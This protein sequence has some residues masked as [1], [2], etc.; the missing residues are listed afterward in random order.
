MIGYCRKHPFLT[1][2][3]VAIV[4]RAL[5]VIMSKGFMAS[6]D[7]YETVNVAYVWLVYGL[8]SD[9]GLLTWGGLVEREISR[10]PLYTLS[11]YGVMKTY[12]AFGVESLDKMMYGIRAVHALLSLVTVGCAYKITERVTRSKDWALIAGLVAAAHAA[13]PFLSVRNLI[14]MVSGHFWLLSIFLIYRYQSG[15][16]DRTLFLAG[17]A[18]GLAWMIRFEL[19]FAVLP[20]PFLLWYERKRLR[21]AFVYSSAVLSMLLLSGVVDLYLIGSFAASTVS[22]IRQVVTERPPYMTHLFIYPAVLL[23][24]FLPP[25]SPLAFYLAGIRQ[26]WVRHRVLFFSSLVFILAHSL[27]PSRQERYMIPIVPALVVLLV[28]AFWWHWSKGG[29][30]FRHKRFLFGL[31]GTAV[32][33][34]LLALLPLTI[35]YGHKG[36]VEPLVRI[37]RSGENTGVVFVSPEEG[38]IYPDFYGG[39]GGLRRGYIHDWADQSF[40]E[41]SHRKQPF[42]YF[43]IYLPSGDDMPRYLDA[44]SS[45]FGPL[46]EWLHVR[47]SSIDFLLHRLNPK[48]NQRNEAWIFRKAETASASS[49]S[50]RQ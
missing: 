21:H 42:T 32:V 3:L 18:A 23:A 28:L 10:F 6:D 24:F 20:V 1:V 34:N 37:E 2:M 13:M 31:L 48:Y 44:L 5:A 38:R 25:L 14:E 17:L 12:L 16:K 33:I 49:L 46:E 4:L 26:F 50:F 22:H 40:L 19:A 36:M 39:F 47:P 30:F 15:G 7:H 41:E 9:T 29:Y 27:S 8:W 43:I 11:L 45:H 35:N